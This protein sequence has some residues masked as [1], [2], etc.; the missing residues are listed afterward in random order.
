[1]MSTTQSG[2]L[3]IIEIRFA[4]IKYYITIIVITEIIVII[5]VI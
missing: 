5:V 4:A 2:G 3:I 1:M